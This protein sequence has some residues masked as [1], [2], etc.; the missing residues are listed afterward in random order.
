[1]LRRYQMVIRS[2]KLKKVRYYND[3]KKK[4][5]Y[6]NDQK[7]KVRYYN[8]QKKKEQKNKQRSTTY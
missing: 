3:Q 1:M 7:K 6:Y 2:H 8:D 5:R 4:V